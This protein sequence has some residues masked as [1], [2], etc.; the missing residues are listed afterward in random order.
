M[1]L[2][3][4][5]FPGTPL[6]TVRIEAKPALKPYEEKNGQL[7]IWDNV[8]SFPDNWKNQN[9]QV[10]IF[11]FSPKLSGK[12]LMTAF[13]LTEIADTAMTKTDLALYHGSEINKIG[14]TE[15]FSSI[16][17]EDTYILKLAITGL[18]VGAYA[19]SLLHP[20]EIK[21]FKSN[22]RLK[23]ATEKGMWGGL[24]YM[25]A[26]L[27]WDTVNFGADVLVHLKL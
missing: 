17:R 14:G 20:K 12:K 5:V 9:E 3:R 23:D 16:G 7:Y 1:S 11:S 10:P 21:I 26:A 4:P 18:L 27:L 6:Q 15:L 8:L 24:I 22:I 2:E 13:F 19:L 25:S